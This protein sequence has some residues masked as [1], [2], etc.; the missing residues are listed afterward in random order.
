M[1]LVK[2]WERMEIWDERRGKKEGGEGRKGRDKGGRGAVS[3]MHA[4]VVANCGQC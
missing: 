1:W 4:D 2:V 3:C